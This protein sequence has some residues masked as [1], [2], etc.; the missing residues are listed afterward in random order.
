LR[1]EIDCLV[2]LL[3]NPSP[4][5]EL[6]EIPIAKEYYTVV[7]QEGHPCNEGAVSIDDLVEQTWVVAPH[8]NPIRA[9]FENLFS[10]PAS[11][12]TIQTCQMMSFSGAEQLLLESDSVALLIYSKQNRQKIREGLRVV[13]IPLPNSEVTIGI[14]IRKNAPQNEAL[15]LFQE[16]LEDEL[17]LN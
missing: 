13:D 16:F 1:G 10:D 3:R 11:I 4:F 5:D 6:E 2:G 9:Y 14:T 12:P 7:A 15:K 8:G 17:Q